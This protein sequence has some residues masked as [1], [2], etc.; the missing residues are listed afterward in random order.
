MDPRVS[1]LRRLL[2]ARRRWQLIAALWLAVAAL[3]YTALTAHPNPTTPRSTLDNLYLTLQLFGLGFS[4]DLARLDW[5]LSFGRFAGLVVTASA[6][7]QAS[8]VL[9]HEQLQQAR[10]RFARGHVVVFGLGEK[11]YRLA[12]GFVGEGHRVVAVERDPAAPHAGAARAQGVTV[13]AGDAADPALLAQ[14]GVGRAAEAIA[15][16]GD[17]GVNAEIAALVRREPRKTTAAPLRCSIHMMDAQLCTLLR[18][19][20]LRDATSGIRVQF[21]NIYESGARLWLSSHPPF[22]DGPAA[23][24]DAAEPHV[25]V[26]GLDEL[27]QSLA[28]SVVQRWAD[29]PGDGS[30]L[31]LTLVDPDASRRLQAMRLRHPGFERHCDATT[32]DLDPHSPTAGTVE[33]F[34]QLVDHGK[35][36]A[37][38]VCFPDD[39]L[40][41]SMGLTMRQ[42]FGGR[43]ALVTVRTKTDMGLAVLLREGSGIGLEGFGLLDRACTTEMIHGGAHEQVAR[44]VHDGYRARNAGSRLAVPWDE[45][46]ERARESNRLAADHIAGGL[47]EIGCDLVPLR[48]WGDSA[49]ELTPAEIETLARREHVR[50][51]AEREHD[52]WQFGAAR[53]DE[54]KRNPLLVDWDELPEPARESNRAAVAQ[55]P[56]LLARAGFEVLR[57]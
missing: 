52:G 23:G 14:A 24:N 28:L 18:H 50:W 30:P 31:R 42:R 57:L 4:I 19:Q 43:R 13:L 25:V 11:G 46:P 20:A 9:F 7:V 51:R 55:L 8:A 45:L 35:P 3:G 54:T 27:G 40:S 22:D 36:T 16:C 26:V 53:D 29:R 39:A 17:D 32:I 34:E 41:L 49:V 10:L 15:A 5:R 56:A 47:A 12:A 21:F 1:S 6:F 38:Y 37:V 48:R 44:A 2:P 33:A